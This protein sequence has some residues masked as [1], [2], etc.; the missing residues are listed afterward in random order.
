MEFKIKINNWQLK[1]TKGGIFNFY[2]W[3]KEDWV[4]ITFIRGKWCGLCRKHLMQIN[5]NLDKIKA[6][7]LAISNDDKMGAAVL[8]SFLLLKF[9]VLPD[10]EFNITEL[11][12]VKTE[13]KDDKKM[14]LPALFL[15]NPKHEIVWAYKG[16][17]FD[18]YLDVKEI[19]KKVAKVKI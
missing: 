6:K 11:L 7:P 4:I 17:N 15:I 14:S 5:E 12:G 1:D 18:D 10:S 8:K 13:I 9:P 16:E 2:N 3:Q 19:I